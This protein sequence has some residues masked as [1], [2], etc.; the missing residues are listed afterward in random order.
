MAR[1][2]LRQ[3]MAQVVKRNR[4]RDGILYMQPTRGAS[5]RNAPFP[6]SIAPT[7]T[8]TARNQPLPSDDLVENGGVLGSVPEI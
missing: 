6:N 3:V 8:M 2:S 1:A 7:L 5:P 4:V